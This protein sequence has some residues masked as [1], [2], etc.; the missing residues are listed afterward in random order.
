M[1]AVELAA[2]DNA[3]TKL[4]QSAH[5]YDAALAHDGAGLPPDRLAKLQEVM[6]TIDQT[7]APGCPACRGGPG[8]RT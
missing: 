2:L 4:K 1:P 6:L 5:A 8:T 3:V 7:L